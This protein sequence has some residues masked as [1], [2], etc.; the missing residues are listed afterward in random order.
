MKLLLSSEQGLPDY[1]LLRPSN[2]IASCAVSSLCPPGA[3]RFEIECSAPMLYVSVLALQTAA[4]KRSQCLCIERLFSFACVH[5]RPGAYP[6][7]HI[8]HKSTLIAMRDRDD[9]CISLTDTSK[10]LKRSKSASTIGCAVA[11]PSAASS[12]AKRS[13][14]SCQP[15]QKDSKRNAFTIHSQTNSLKEI[16]A[17]DADP[18]SPQKS[19]GTMIIGILWTGCGK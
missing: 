11:L 6:V 16:L 9:D 5:A 18:F 13:R 1:V 4:P 8:V 7:Q 12:S 2:A 17:K 19:S 15:F 10:N 14:S 3:Q